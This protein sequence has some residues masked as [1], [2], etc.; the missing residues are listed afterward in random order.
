MKKI[1]TVLAALFC[2]ATLF[3]QPHMNV[4][5]QNTHLWRGEEVASGFVMTTEFYVADSKDKFRVGFWGGA[6][7]T[8]QYKEF[9]YWAS[10]TARNLYLAVAD[11]Y[12]FST[13]ATY[14]N[15]EFFNYI[16]SQTGRFL[17]AKIKYSI[18]KKSPVLLS[19]STVVFGRDR[20]ASNSYNRY[21]TFCSVEYPIYKKD[22]WRVDTRVG[23]AFA[24]N[25][26]DNSAN[27]YGDKGGIVEASLKVSNKI[28]IGKY[29]IPVSLL[30][31]WNPQ[32]NHGYMQFCSRIVSF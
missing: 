25:N 15:E 31:M 10:Y 28:R 5:I 24:L 32:S 12:N 14:N 21:S 22:D 29:E 27:F 11:T 16:P 4:T 1:F 7:C 2:S 19:W 18:G 30:M 17:D 23:A 20:D 13:Y 3:A 9:N 6:N 26:I 8:G